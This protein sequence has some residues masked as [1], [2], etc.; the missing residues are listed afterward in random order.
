MLLNYH[1]EETC[2]SEYFR[3]FEFQCPSNEEHV[4]ATYLTWNY[5]HLGMEEVEQFVIFMASYELYTF[6]DK[7]ETFPIASQFKDLIATILD[8][9]IIE[10][11]ENIYVIDTRKRAQESSNILQEEDDKSLSLRM[12]VQSQEDD[13]NDEHLENEELNLPISRSTN[14]RDTQDFIDDKLCSYDSDDEED[15]QP[16]P[17]E[18]IIDNNFKM[19]R[20]MV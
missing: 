1:E 16:M 12:P 9:C 4:I 6:I 14:D 15:Y 17:N 2:C 18:V 10:F 8:L 19:M 13:E 7:H 3:H 5:A 20:S 11:N